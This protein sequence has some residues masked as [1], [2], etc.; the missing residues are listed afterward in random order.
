MVAVGGGLVV[1]FLG[2]ALLAAGQAAALSLLP[3]VATLAA[4]L[5]R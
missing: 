1:A 5:Q 3:L 2:A 4:F